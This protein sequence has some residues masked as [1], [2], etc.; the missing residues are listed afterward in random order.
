MSTGYD[1]LNN[2][3]RML[4]FSIE[5]VCGVEVGCGRVFNEKTKRKE[6]SDVRH[7][8]CFIAVVHLEYSHSQIRRFIGY[9]Y[10]SNVNYAIRRMLRMIEY[11]I[12]YRNRIYN[13]SIE[14][15]IMGLTYQVIKIIDKKRK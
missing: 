8:F 15:G 7:I 14:L 12:A 11:N 3:L 5:R 10:D 13:I 2:E 9:K 4:M 1:A 6:L